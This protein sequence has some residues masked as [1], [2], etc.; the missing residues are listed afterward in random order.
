MDYNT[1]EGDSAGVPMYREDIGDMGR[2]SSSMD[3]GYNATDKLVIR[4][5]IQA[6]R[7]Q[8]QICSADELDQQVTPR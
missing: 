4:L 8:G 2:S 1:I 7:Y 3:W 6:N 5:A